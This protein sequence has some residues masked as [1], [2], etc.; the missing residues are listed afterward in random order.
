MAVLQVRC[1]VI[2][3]EALGD[4][5]SQPA[6]SQARRSAD[7]R[8]HGQLDFHTSSVKDTHLF[9]FVTP[10]PPSP[11]TDCNLDKQSRSLIGHLS[12]SSD[13]LLVRLLKTCALEPRPDALELDKKRAVSRKAACDEL[14]SEKKLFHS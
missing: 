12:C 14:S 5:C 3:S 2:A 8:G 4:K 13:F 7:S 10:I 1:A 9:P 6:C 11:K